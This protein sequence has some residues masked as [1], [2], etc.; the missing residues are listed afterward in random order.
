MNSKTIGE[1]IKYHRKRLGMTQ[2]QLAERMGVS[3]QAVSKWEN[4]LS[5][6]DI[7]VLPELAD[8]FGISV[9]E[10]LGRSVS[11]TAPVK[12]AEPVNNEAKAFVFHTS[13]KKGGICFALFVLSL[14]VLLLMRAFI[15]AMN[16]SSWTIIWTTSLI[17]LG[18][19]GLIGGFSMF[20][21]VMLL[22]GLYFL[23]TSYFFLPFKLGWNI[24]IPV[25][26]LLWGLSLLFDILLGKKP[27]RHYWDGESRVPHKHRKGKLHRE[28][29]CNNGYLNC[30]LSFGEY[31]AAVV[32]AM[33]RGGSIDSNFGDFTVD[34]SACE[35]LAPDCRVDVD[36]S[37]GSLTLLV[38]DRFQV[39]IEENSSF[40]SAPEVKGSP[41][42]NAEGVL[43]ITA[44]LSFGSLE[45]RYI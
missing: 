45:I 18:V 20:C 11:D 33:L 2:E 34:F 22:A 3:A 8:I 9:D 43:H 40:S 23:L 19:S 30:E 17:F 26:L 39:E 27:W 16:I 35:A 38:P 29:S 32:T 24:V 21:F 1:R 4:N 5:C 41:A 6:P 7:S 14:A 37:F 36:N 10:L 44:D 42:P 15:P 31:R 13:S 25:A 28:Y 12:E